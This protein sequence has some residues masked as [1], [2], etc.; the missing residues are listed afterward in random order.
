[1]PSKWDLTPTWVITLMIA[2]EDLKMKTVIACRCPLC[3]KISQILC[4]E[5][6]WDAYEAGALA[7]E[8]FA[9]MNVFERE[10]IISGMCED[11]QMTFFEEED[12]DCDGECD[13]CFDF[14]CPS[15]ASY[16]DPRDEE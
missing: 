13:I 4:E 6:A 14:D 1:M 11:C 5:S 10:T 9:D 3:G 16:F 2:K 8:A 7:Q 15:N 12:E